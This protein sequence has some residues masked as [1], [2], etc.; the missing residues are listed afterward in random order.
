MSEQ[1]YIKKD[2]NIE[3]ILDQ[4]YAS[5]DS[6]EILDNINE[7]TQTYFNNLC[8]SPRK[9]RREVRERA[10]STEEYTLEKLLSASR[11]AAGG[12]ACGD[13]GMLR[14]SKWLVAH[15]EPSFKPAIGENPT[16]LSS[17]TQLNNCSRYINTI[18]KLIVSRRIDIIVFI[19]SG[20]QPVASLIS[21][22]S[23]TPI[24]GLRYSHFTRDD[25]KVLYPKNSG[26]EHY[27]KLFIDKNVLVVDDVIDTGETMEKVANF[28]KKTG[29]NEIYLS[30]ADSSYTLGKKEYE[31]L[32]RSGTY[33]VLKLRKYTKAVKKKE[34]EPFFHQDWEP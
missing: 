1:G 13:E 15:T 22:Y 10:W 24:V 26:F 32:S 6:L 23:G 5:E 21:F 28:L 2:R 3:G 33:A 16:R 29:A 25:K 20:G 31:N 30:A 7:I 4:L 12:F 17:R 9:S 27:E 11:Y 19:A 8:T 18:N 34:R 14:F